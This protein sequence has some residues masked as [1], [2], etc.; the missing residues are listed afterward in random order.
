M[1]VCV[2]G[3]GGGVGGGAECLRVCVC[4]GGWVGACGSYTFVWL[5]GLTH[6]K[7]KGLTMKHSPLLHGPSVSNGL[8]YLK[9]IRH[10]FWLFY[11]RNTCL[12]FLVI[13]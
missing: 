5:I 10:D 1:C 6:K 12:R 4:V 3:G 9:S 2:R 13:M 7:F 11:S 8:E